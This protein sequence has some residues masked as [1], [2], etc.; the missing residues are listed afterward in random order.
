MVLGF[1]YEPLGRQCVWCT[2]SAFYAAEVPRANFDSLEWALATVFCC[3]TG[4]NWNSVMYDA[5]RASNS[6]ASFYFVS[7]V[8][9]GSFIIMNLFLAILLN[10]LD[11]SEVNSF[12][13][14]P[15]FDMVH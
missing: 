6:M 14:F 4:E 2:D 3:L 12:P 10:N 5:R 8:V 15:S 11:L 13:P 7:L 9:F 1:T